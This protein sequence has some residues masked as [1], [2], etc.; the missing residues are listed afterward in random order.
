M[1]KAVSQDLRDRVVAAIDGGLSRHGAAAQFV[2][3]SPDCY[4]LEVESFHCLA[5]G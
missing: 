4:H 2:A 5:D 3:C 1:A